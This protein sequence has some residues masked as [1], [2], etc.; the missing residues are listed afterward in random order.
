[1]QWLGRRS[2]LTKFSV[3]MAV[4]ALPL[5]LLYPL[6]VLPSLRAQHREERVA[7]LKP[8]VESA[9]G[10]LE[11]Y[12]AKEHAG[13][14]SREQAQAAAKAL[15]QGLRYAGTEYFWVNDLE[16]RLVMHPFLPAMVGKDMSGYRDPL[17]KPV[18]S[19]IVALAK[20]RGEGSVEYTATRAGST[21]YI[22]KVSYVKRFEPWGWVLG[23]GVY[24]EDIEREAAEAQ[25]K[26]LMGLA[27]A[28]LLAVGM[29]LG[30]SR[31]V[32]RPVKALAD[33]A[34]QVARGDLHVTVPVESE[35]EVGRL[36]QAFNA[37]VTAIQEMVGGLG[38][39][40][41]ATAADAERIGHSTEAM[42]RLSREQS[43]Q[44]RHMAESVQDMSRGVSHGAEEARGT[45]AAAAASG[46]TAAEGSEV[47]EHTARKITEIVEV[48]ERAAQTVG[49]LQ[50][51]GEV[52]AQ[53]LRAIEDVAEET[54]MVAINTAIEAARAG[55]NGK[56]FGV[57]AAEI[58]KLAHRSREVAQQIGTLLQ[59]NQEDTG[60]A[61]ALMRQGTAKVREGLTL[62]STTGEALARIVSSAD[63]MAERVGRLAEDNAKSSSAGESLAGRMQALSERS[64]ETAAGVDQI[65]RAVE[66]LEARARQLRE[67]AARFKVA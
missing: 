36:G 10:I 1:M 53:M 32:V 30:F 39:V 52:V 33:A 55:E 5:L 44:L 45:A 15:L 57:V 21:E 6:Y 37:M 42:R 22:P 61:V 7:A 65:G 2:L 14:L 40:A 54:Q 58:R 43:E 60:A 12:A 27:V 4:V 62:S 63:A 34:H 50:T 26:L 59:Q 31:S 46:R 35:D 16:A 66:D 23:T 3:A 49:R 48:V 13:E 8:V 20:S 24:V 25:R 47:V 41:R 17:G 9:F 28:A 67:M 29:G 19:D 18:F 38:E 64:V 56:G 51:S 11:A